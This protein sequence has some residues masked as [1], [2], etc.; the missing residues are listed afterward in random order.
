[1]RKFLK[2]ATV[3]VLAGVLLTGNIGYA[4]AAQ[5]QPADTITKSIVNETVF[6]S[7]T[8]DKQQSK[9]VVQAKS[10]KSTNAAYNKKAKKAYKKFLKGYFE[11]GKSFSYGRSGYK[12]NYK[13]SEHE[14]GYY[15]IY[16]INNDG[17]LELI[18]DTSDTYLTIDSA[19]FLYYKGKVKCIGLSQ[20]GYYG[21]PFCRMGKFIRHQ[22]HDCIAKI[23][24]E[25][26]TWKYSIIKNGKLKTVAKEFESITFAGDDSLPVKRYWIGKKIV[27]KKKFDNFIKK[28]AGTKN[29]KIIDC[30]YKYVQ[31]K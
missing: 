1:M 7:Q 2:S 13:F 12:W 16:D 17:K 4:Q 22:E 3:L 19:L 11:K 6:V 8:V 23:K 15:L 27:S 9:A 29:P 18:L 5:E 25:G 21:G 14:G 28:N 10:K 26:W 20:F 31:Y 24:K 30:S